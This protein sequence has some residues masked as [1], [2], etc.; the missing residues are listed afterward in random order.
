M[1]TLI[2]IGSVVGVILIIFVLS[3]VGASRYKKAGPHQASIHR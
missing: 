3:A 2:V 1:T